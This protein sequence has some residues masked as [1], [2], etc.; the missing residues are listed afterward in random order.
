[1]WTR[2]SRLA[3]DEEAKGGTAP[4]DARRSVSLGP[5]GGDPDEAISNQSLK[6][7]PASKSRQSTAYLPSPNAPQEIDRRKSIEKGPS[8][9]RSRLANN[10][11]WK[12]VDPRNGNAEKTH[13]TEPAV[14]TV[15]SKEAAVAGKTTDDT[16]SS[17]RRPR[18]RSAW[19]C[20]LLTL[21]TTLVSIIGLA[22]V[23]H[24]FLHRQRDTKGCRMS[25]MRPSFAK[26][27]D[28]D[29]EHTR[30]ASKYSTYLYREGMV[31]ED[32][33][34]CKPALLSKF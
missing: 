30:F 13:S 19:S 1:M 21:L 17:T 18:L 20:S 15:T 14:L 12:L 24:G 5:G 29:T 7:N 11:N 22:T 8:T 26:L 2:L 25:Y 34:V 32:T 33:K 16:R 9:A 27:S 23:L 28:F 3:A 10:E 4:L 31:D 6:S